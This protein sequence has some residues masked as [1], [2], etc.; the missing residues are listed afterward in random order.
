MYFGMAMPDRIGSTTITTIS[1]ISVNAR[2]ARGFMARFIVESFPVYE[3]RWRARGPNGGI[4][5][6]HCGAR[7]VYQ[8]EPTA[9]CTDCRASDYPPRAG[10]RPRGHPRV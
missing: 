9:T 1:S 4:A 8:P 5:G 3:W 6:R 2:V 7:P 10:A